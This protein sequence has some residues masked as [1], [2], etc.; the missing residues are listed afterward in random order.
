[1]IASFLSKI[2]CF[3]HV[4]AIPDNVITQ[5]KAEGGILYKEEHVRET[6]VLHEFRTPGIYCSWRKITFFGFFVLSAKRIVVHAGLYNKIDVDTSYDDAAFQKIHFSIRPKYLSIS[7]NAADL[8]PKSSGQVEIRLHL[9][10]ISA[11]GNI[12]QQKGASIA[13][14]PA[15]H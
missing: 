12:L 4:G 6:A 9:R 5:L 15:I 14:Q 10:D 1:M 8:L 7:F 13:D 3:F 11:A 2:A